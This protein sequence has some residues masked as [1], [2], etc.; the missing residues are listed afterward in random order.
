MHRLPLISLVLV[1]ATACGGNPSAEH[2]TNSD[3]TS[4]G[5]DT[6]GGSSAASDTPEFQ[7]HDTDKAQGDHPSQI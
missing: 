1:L 5:S 7:L 2:A 3:S 6:S 4:A